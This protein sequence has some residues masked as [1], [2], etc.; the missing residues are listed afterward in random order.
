MAHLNR[1]LF[2]LCATL[3]VASGL[4]G[5]LRVQ[6][7]QKSDPKKPKTW[8]TYTIKGDEFAVAL[9]AVPA[10]STCETYN[11]PLKRM[12]SGRLLN[13][14]EGRVVYSVEVYENV[15][16]KLSLEEFV[17]EETAQSPFD[18]TAEKK[19]T[20]DGFAGREF[21]SRNKSSP[22]VVQFLATEQ[23]L[24]R[25]AVTGADAKQ[26][27]VQRF[28]SSIQLGPQSAGIEVSQ[29]PKDPEEI[30]GERLYKTKEID[31][32]IKLLMKPEPQYTQEAR[33][34][35]IT[36]TV[37]LKAV[38]SA[39]GH[40]TNIRVVRGLPLGLTEQSIAVAR[41]IR[42]TPA[43]KDR[44]PVSMWVQ[45]EYYFSLTND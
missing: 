42:F 27:G 5:L 11:R 13:M 15:E 26:E 19:L 43:M 23:R 4:T 40:V 3:V 24:Y 7:Q 32:K 35:G 2:S 45:L 21:S 39:S 36:G 31:V 10:I 41:Q 1:I 25:F 12:L 20:V 9:P 44:K 8:M 22:A 29:P 14:T 18:V 16:P 30:D 34:K 33:K 28:F 37:I 17:A 6:A 38:F